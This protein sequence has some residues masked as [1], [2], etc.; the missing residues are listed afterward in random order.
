MFW[1][2]RVMTNRDGVSPQSRNVEE[3]FG[4]VSG[5][6]RSP[7]LFFAHVQC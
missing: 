6:L 3:R 7:L 4:V 1:G 5:G 2:Q